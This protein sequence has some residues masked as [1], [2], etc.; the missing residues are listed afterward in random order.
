MIASITIGIIIGAITPTPA[1]AQDQSIGTINHRPILLAHSTTVTRDA[2]INVATKFKRG[3][4]LKATLEK[5][6]NQV[7]SDIRI[8]GQNQSTASVQIDP[9]TGDVLKSVD[10]VEDDM[11]PRYD[12]STFK[13]GRQFVGQ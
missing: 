3:K 1:P 10:D 6:D 12:L 5:H 13:G 4:V 9:R 2:A 11:S 8:E 7:V